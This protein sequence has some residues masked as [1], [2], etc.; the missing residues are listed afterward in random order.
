M[1]REAYPK[2]RALVWALGTSYLK[3]DEISWYQEK[4]TNNKKLN[5]IN[6]DNY[7]FFV[8]EYEEGL[9][10]RAFWAPER[11]QKTIMKI[12]KRIRKTC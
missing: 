4:I 10:L 11:D 6:F 8:V 12:I 9:V 5:L 7:I 3:Y 1:K 2:Y